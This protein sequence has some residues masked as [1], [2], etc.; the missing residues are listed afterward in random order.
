MHEIVNSRKF[1]MLVLLAIFLNTVV[2]GIE[3][4]GQSRSLE[5]VLL[6]RM[7]LRAPVSRSCSGWTG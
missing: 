2:L 3:H 4:H 6:V 5:K 7:L 1:N